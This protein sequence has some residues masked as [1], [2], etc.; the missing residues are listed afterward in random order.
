MFL[1]RLAACLLLLLPICANAV[2]FQDLRWRLIGPFR[3]GRVLAVTGVPGEPEHFYFGSVNGGVWETNDAGRT[4]QPIFDAQP[5]QSIG[6]L[7]VAPSDP[8][9]IYAGTGEADMRSDIAQ[10]DGMYKSTDR[11]KTWTHIGL[12]DSQQ[13]GRVVV[14][15]ADPN[16]VFVAALG[17]PYAANAERGVFRTRDGGKTWTKVLGPDANTGA[18]DLTLEPGHPNVVYAA[19]WATRRTPWSV[20]PPSNGPGSGVFK[21][22]DGG[23]HWTAL[24]NGL[25]EARP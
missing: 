24:T 20:Y 23:D 3:G 16:T 13:I 10:G 17:H 18:I 9:T 6:A 22:T 1:R 14:H 15:P 7:A 12:P 11:G 21:S 4:W 19:L 8:K 2:D 25:Q 5:T